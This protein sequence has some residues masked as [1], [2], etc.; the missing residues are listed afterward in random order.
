MV[1][2][3]ELRG[4]P[5]FDV[6]KAFLG[7]L[8]DLAFVDG[9]QYAGITHI[10]YKGVDGY[11]RKVAF[12]FVKQ[13][14]ETPKKVAG[15]ELE[16]N[17]TTR[18]EDITQFF[19]K[20]SDLLVSEILDKQVVD[21]NG[22]KIVRVNDVLLGKVGGKFCVVAVA[23]GKR[24][25]FRRLGLGPF[26]GRRLSEHVI[27]WESVEALEP[28]LHGLHLKVQ[29]DRVADLHPEDI[30]DVMED[31]SHNERALIFKSLNTKKAAE[32]LIGSEPDV[33][34]SVLKNMKMERIKDLLEDIPSDQAADI[35]SLMGKSK[36]DKLLSSM[37]PDTAGRIRGIL[38]YPPESAA[39][40]MDTSYIA[41]TEDCT[42]Q[43]TIDLL[44]KISP[45]SETIYHI[46]VVDLE[47]HPVGVLS[48]RR[49]IIAPPQVKVSE[50]MKK[51]VI[52]V[53]LSTTKEDVAKAI[54]KYDLFVIPVVD[55]ANI[56]RGIVRADD[57]LTEIMPKEWKR[58]RYMP[59]KF[60]LKK[61][62]GAQ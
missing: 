15:S 33:Q 54:A 53:R 51:E 27:P 3:S 18:E 62:N 6:D 52:H 22:A 10:V 38:N 16:M 31:L 7:S 43:G 58:H 9:E 28:K 49:L 34:E 59:H 60:K 35:L 20:P 2:F 29:K 26:I 40:I 42:A 24:S 57:V 21:V 39:A 25:L 1:Y 41:V 4:R 36:A 50:I 56:L 13:L 47:N 5:V 55:D 8:V 44:R 61:K 11:K 23:V 30:A 17:L 37:R 12:G 45:P 32:A 14:A 19:L 48:I 46:Y